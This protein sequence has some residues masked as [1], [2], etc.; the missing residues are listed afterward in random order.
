MA[1]DVQK[2]STAPADAVEN[3]IDPA[4]R[5]VR[6][7]K[8]ARNHILA[9]SGVGLVPI[10]FVD[11][12]G[13]IGVQLDLIKKLSIEYGVPFDKDRG[14][15]ILAALLGSVFPAV[16]GGIGA[17]LLKCIP[18]IGQTAGAVTSPVLYGASTYAVYK[19]FVQHYEAGGTILDLDPAKVKKYF[20]EQFLAGKNVAADLQ[21]KAS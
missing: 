13:V 9:S 6:L 18:I 16:M 2:N 19:V 7:E 8:M 15:S 11:I 20:S 1:N 10:P 3:A 12:V 14:K 21:K 17:S 5:N 4:A